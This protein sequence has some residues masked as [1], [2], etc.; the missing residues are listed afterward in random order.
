M[1]PNSARLRGTA[2]FRRFL[3]SA[4]A[5][6]LWQA[7]INCSQTTSPYLPLV[8]VSGAPGSAAAV[9]A[10]PASP[11]S[12][13]ILMQAVEAAA[14]AVSALWL[15]WRPGCRAGWRGSRDRGL[16]FLA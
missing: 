1:T 4:A 13:V 6:C 8:G 11:Q 14:V 10:L 16:S 2:C 5:A 12:F 15:V 3:V 7:P 9:I